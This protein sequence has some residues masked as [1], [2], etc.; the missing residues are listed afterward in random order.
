MNARLIQF[1]K[2]ELAV[3]EKAISIAL[4]HQ[5]PTTNQIPMILWQ[6]G[7]ITLEDLDKIFDWMETAAA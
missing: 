2:E 1:L 4:R 5:D 7:L 6:Y 3:P